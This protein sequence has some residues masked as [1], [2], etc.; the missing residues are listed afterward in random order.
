M[1]RSRARLLADRP[2]GRGITRS[3]LE[4]VV[5][6]PRLDG[7]QS[8][9]D[10]DAAL[11]EAAE[12]LTSGDPGI[13][14]PRVELL[15]TT[16]SHAAVVAAAPEPLE[17]RARLV[18]GLGENELRPLALDFVEQSHLLIL[19]ESGA[20][21]TATLRTLCREIVR[22]NSVAS[23]RL[24]I[25]DYRRSLLGVVVTDHL[26]GYAMSRATAT[27]HLD[28]LT[29]T[30]EARMP[31]DDVS[32]TQ[33]RDRSWWSGPEIF[34]IVDD[35][36]LVAT[37]SDNPLIPLVEMLPHARDVGLHL[38]LARRSGGATRAMF[39]PVLARMRELGCM[40]LMM[41][42]NP[43]EGPL[44]GSVRPSAM[45]PGRGVVVRRREQDQVVQVGWIEPP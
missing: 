30:L 43:E 44:F 9:A 2:P 8:S 18:L 20:G 17:G 7:K 34:V 6:L 5:A 22:T 14:A 32:Q 3:G 31:P 41:S 40:G 4:L 21:K 33:L 25:V 45:P 19:G 26:A 35:Y 15:P 10:L 39:D 28:A 13:R 27:S 1:D 38:I 12:S 29:R 11:F 36:D 42:A 37:A 16:V 23:G 24:V